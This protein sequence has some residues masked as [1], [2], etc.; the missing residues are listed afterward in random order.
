MF[1]YNEFGAGLQLDYY[2]LAKKRGFFC[3]GGVVT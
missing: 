2:G 3:I 1:E